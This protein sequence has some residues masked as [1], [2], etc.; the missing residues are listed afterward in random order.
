MKHILIVLALLSISLITG[1]SGAATPDVATATATMIVPS[2][3]ATFTPT[4]TALP[5]T[6][7]ATASGPLEFPSGGPDVTGEEQPAGQYKTPRGFNPRFTFETTTAFRGISETLPLGDLFG[8][9]QGSRRLP[10][11]QLLFWT[12]APGVS[13]EEAVAQLRATSRVE[14]SP[15]QSVTIIGISGTQ[16]DT[17]AERGAHFAALGDLTGMEGGSWDTNSL[18]VHIRFIVF[19]A[20]GRTMV[21]YIETPTDEFDSFVIDTEKVLGTVQFD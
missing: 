14:F 13:T 4:S 8:L 16:F 15:E 11:K 17:I 7:T 20:S 21:I 10:Q 5:P 18:Q 9:A 12:L 3:T 2:A 1:C 6:L 19:T